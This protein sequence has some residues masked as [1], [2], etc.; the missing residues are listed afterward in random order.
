MYR[1][2]PFRRNYINENSIKTGTRRIMRPDELSAL[3]R[4]ERQMFA[5]V[6]PRRIMRL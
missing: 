1:A 5:Q 3:V 4:L 2:G 6:R